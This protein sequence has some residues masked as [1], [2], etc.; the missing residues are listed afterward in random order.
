MREFRLVE[1][2]SFWNNRGKYVLGNVFAESKL[3]K[4]WNDVLAKW[5]GSLEM[6]NYH[7]SKESLGEWYVKFKLVNEI[8]K[9]N[10]F[11]I[12]NC[13]SSWQ[14]SGHSIGTIHNEADLRILWSDALAK[15]D[16]SLK[17]L[18]C[19]FSSSEF[20]GYFIEFELLEDVKTFTK[21]DLKTGMW[22][23]TRNGKKGIVLL[24]VGAES[25][26]IISGKIWCPLSTYDEDLTDIDASK[27][28]DIVK[29]YQPTSNDEYLRSEDV[30]N[31]ELLWKRIEK[32]QKQI[33]IE[34]IELEMEKLAKKLK[35]LGV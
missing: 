5:D 19:C 35:D 3:R 8:R 28:Y 20:Y 24:G 9:T 15:W 34:L 33:D 10:N 26:D 18:N 4:G 6:L 32:T 12:V 16:G 11:K 23:E 31:F 30:N 29:V 17:M 14:I 1:K 25:K 22:I 2:G 13:G 7:L 21:K 27:E